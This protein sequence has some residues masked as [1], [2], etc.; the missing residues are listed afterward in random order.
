MSRK[1]IITIVVLSFALLELLAVRQ[2]Q[3]NN[4]HAM[5]QLDKEINKKNEELNKIQ[6]EIEVVCS[7]SSLHNKISIVEKTDGLH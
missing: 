4:V 6:I 2:E 5:E 1:L 3:I 7:P